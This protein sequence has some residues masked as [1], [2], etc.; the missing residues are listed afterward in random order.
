[1]LHFILYLHQNPSVAIDSAPWTAILMVTIEKLFF[2]QHVF[3][4]TVLIAERLFAD[5]VAAVVVK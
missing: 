3:F 2:V 1:M 4:W 5:L